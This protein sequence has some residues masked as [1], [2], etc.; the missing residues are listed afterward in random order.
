MGGAIILNIHQQI[1]SLKKVILI[2][3]LVDSIGNEWNYKK[4]INHEFKDHS[5]PKKWKELI[6]KINTYD[7]G[8]WLRLTKLLSNF[9]SDNFSY[10]FKNLTLNKSISWNL[11]YGE[12]DFLID[13]DK[14][15]KW[16]KKL[17]PKTKVY[18]MCNERHSPHLKHP[19]L[20]LEILNEII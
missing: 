7:Y 2:N 5:N 12:Y 6:K 19:I 11:I 10:Y 14:T 9:K 20:F 18:K 4:I 1:P 16:I 3:P 8:Q 15:A 13:G 17:N